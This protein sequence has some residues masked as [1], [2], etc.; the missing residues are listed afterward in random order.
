MTKFSRYAKT[1]K[2]CTQRLNV[3]VKLVNLFFLLKLPGKQEFKFNKIREKE[4]M[5]LIMSQRVKDFKNVTSISSPYLKNSSKQ[6]IS[7]NS[8][9][10]STSVYNEFNM[11]TCMGW[12]G[13]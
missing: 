13:Q 5:L 9:G 1:G 8:E 12:A 3:L 11:W 6:D 2:M 4:E 7:V 10:L